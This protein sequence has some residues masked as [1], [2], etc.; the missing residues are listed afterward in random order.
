MYDSTYVRCLL[1]KFIETESRIVVTRG[2]RLW[3]YGRNGEVVFNGY[4]VSVENDDKVLEMD[5][6]VGY[7]TM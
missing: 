5:G 2:W 6:G 3:G 7:T 1:I 4:R